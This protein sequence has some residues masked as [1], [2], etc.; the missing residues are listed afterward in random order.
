MIL[1]DTGYL[2]A[3]LDERDALHP[4][5]LTWARA[6]LDRLLVSEYVLWET[7]NACSK[8][9][10]RPKVHALLAHIRAA[11]AYEI[12]SASRDLF[13][14]GVRTHGQRSDKEWSLTD[15][16]SFILMQER[17]ITSALTHDHDF[18]QA[19]FEALLRRDP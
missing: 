12:V 3:L 15:C 2:L 18:E 14:A 7:I 17:G 5:A 4:R 10:N 19:G 6:T 8:P 16:L 9:V 13:E 11:P 1:V